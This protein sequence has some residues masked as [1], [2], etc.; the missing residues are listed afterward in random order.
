MKLTVDPWGIHDPI[1]PLGCKY[2]YIYSVGRLPLA[3]SDMGSRALS[4]RMQRQHILILGQFATNEP[5]WSVEVDITCVSR[6]QHSQHLRLY[7]RTFMLALLPSMGYCAN[8]SGWIVCAGCKTPLSPI[9][10]VL[11]HYYHKCNG[12][13]QT[14]FAS[15]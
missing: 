13:G 7:I 10:N 12:S 2:I 5:F 4:C 1:S 3:S 15:V 6:K 8:G 11:A 9:F 14:I